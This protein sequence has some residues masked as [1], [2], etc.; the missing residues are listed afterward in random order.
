MKTCIST[1]SYWRMYADRG[2]TLYEAIDKTKELDA[3]AVEFVLDDNPP[4]GL[5]LSEYAVKLTDYAHKKGL[6]TPIYTTGADFF[7]NDAAAEVERVKKHV[8]AA[9]AAGLKL[10]RHDIT[11]RFPDNYTGMRTFEAI[12]PIVA[13]AI[14]EV[15]EYAA[16]KGVMTC[17][18][19]HGRLIQDSGRL[20]AIF[21]AVNHPNYKY[22]CDIGNFEEADENIASAVSK[23]LPFIVHVHAK[24]SFRKTGMWLN[25][26]YGWYKSRAGFYRRATIYG[27]GDNP[28]FQCLSIIY[29]S[30]YRGYVSLEF[31]GIEDT[32]I[33]IEAG[34]ANLKRDIGLIRKGY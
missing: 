24:D 20:L 19:N 1:Y 5:S 29:G 31:E 21:N 13:P 10:M 26:G 8:D 30:G 4:D 28:T 16:S 32:L 22:L 2:W 23:L 3:D 33:G 6:E 7:H 34:L 12:L 15:A 14:R 18:E 11:A 9:A 25:P 17:S 27:Q